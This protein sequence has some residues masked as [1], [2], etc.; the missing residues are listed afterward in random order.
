MTLDNPLSGCVCPGSKIADGGNCVCPSG[1]FETADRQD[2]VAECPTG[3]VS[4]GDAE[5]PICILDCRTHLDDSSENP[6]AILIAGQ[7]PVAGLESGFTEEGELACRCPNNSIQHKDSSNAKATGL[8]SAPQ[9][10]PTTI[11]GHG[12]R[13]TS[14]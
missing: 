5:N 3:Q 14:P 1:Q 2:C 13:T 9:H 7:S 11:I 4:N 8:W 6:S 10:A 12:S